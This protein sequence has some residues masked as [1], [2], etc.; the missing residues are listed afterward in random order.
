MCG[1]GWQRDGERERRRHDGGA[2]HWK[3]P[4]GCLAVAPTASLTQGGLEFLFALGFG[5]STGGVS[6]GSGRLGRRI[7]GVEPPN[8]GP[9]SSS[10]RGGMLLIEI[11]SASYQGMATPMLLPVAVQVGLIVLVA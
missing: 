7:S 3:T 10:Q 11:S 6:A 1:Y 9:R 4:S 2:C 8:A 5:L